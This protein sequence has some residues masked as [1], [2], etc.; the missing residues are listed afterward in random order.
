M[1][2]RYEKILHLAMARTICGGGPYHCSDACPTCHA[3]QTVLDALEPLIPELV[4]AAIEDA[5]D[6]Q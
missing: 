2:S 1:T 4:K 3:Y 5:E 6:D